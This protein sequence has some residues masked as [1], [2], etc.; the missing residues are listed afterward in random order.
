MSTRSDRSTRSRSDARNEV[1]G[2]ETQE[3]V[4]PPGETTPPSGS[5]SA[6]IRQSQDIPRR[7]LSNA[8][9]RGW[10]E[11]PTY[12]EAMS[13]PSFQSSTLEGGVPPPRTPTLKD[14]TST[15]F[16]GLLNKAGMSS[17]RMPTQRREMTQTSDSRHS[18]TSLL[19]QPQTSRL[20]TLT[21]SSTVRE[22][23]ISPY[24]S[25]WESTHS[26]LHISSPVPNTA[27]RASFD[28][29]TMPKAGLSNDQMKFLSSSEAVNLVGVKMGDVPTNKR[30][31]RSEANS[32]SGSPGRG[33]DELPPPSWEDIQAEAGPSGSGS[34]QSGDV[35]D[36]SPRAGVVDLPVVE[37]DITDGR[38]VTGPRGVDLPTI[39]IPQPTTGTSEAP[40]V[41]IEPP[42][43][44]SAYNT[45]TLGSAAST[46]GHGGTSSVTQGGST[47]MPTTAM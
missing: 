12:L 43:P 23:S 46:G 4:L 18:S 6:P 39:V 32:L 11:A 31:R 20:S 25:P 27:M 10:G 26:L 38:S 21:S 15:S 1:E 34:A 30:R 29:N 35:E 45:P 17:F 19:L 3:L 24:T 7:T 44:I 2:E 40:S 13:S 47:A 36:V 28:A 9:R 33:V 41:E 14:R 5:Q 22:G 37:G 42:T 8:S 16:R